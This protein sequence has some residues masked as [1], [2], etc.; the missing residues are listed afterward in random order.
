[1][2]RFFALVLVLILAAAVAYAD[3]TFWDNGALNGR[4]DR[5]DANTP[6]CLS[7]GWT[8]YDDFLVPNGIGAIT[9][10][11]FVDQVDQGTW[12]DYISTNWTLF[13][14]A[15]PFGTPTYSGTA[16]FT[17]TDLGNGDMQLSL[18]GLNI[19]VT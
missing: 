16:V 6:T 3:T 11:S 8:V 5:C 1:M 17:L 9:G 19:P 14:A 4:T 12:A 15:T 7:T 18:S 10:F 2:K 13:N